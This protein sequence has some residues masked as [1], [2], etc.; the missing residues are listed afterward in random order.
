MDHLIREIRYRAPHMIGPLLG[1]LALVYFG[2]HAVQGERGL[3]AWVKYSHQVELAETELAALTER[4]A[5]LE[6]R[7]A[8][9]RPDSLDLDLLDERSRAVLNLAH[10]DEIVLFNPAPVH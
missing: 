5:T 9:L 8:L 6:H 7:V 4:R 10:P 3:L 2:F 1:A